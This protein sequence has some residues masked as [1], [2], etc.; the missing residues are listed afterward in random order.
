MPRNPNI[1]CVCV[2]CGASF[3]VYSSDQK[4]G[5]DRF[6]SRGCY[7][8]FRTQPLAD[9]FW[10]MVDTSGDCWEWTGTTATSGYGSISI[11]RGEVGRAHRVAWELV[12]G[13]VPSGRFV[14]HRCDNRRCVNPAHLFLGSHQD[15]MADMASKGR[16]FSRTRPERVARGE[17]N[18]THTHPERI[19]RGDR[20]AMRLHPESVSRGEQNGN[21]VL[22]WADVRDMRARSAA[23]AGT[24]E[25]GH[26]FGVSTTTVRSILAHKTW[27]DTAAT[28]A[29]TEA[30]Q[31]QGEEGDT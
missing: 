17:R 16:H 18:G 28:E 15:N 11:R 31:S 27:K 25:L 20:S 26:M 24:T 10:S 12:N 2:Q 19:A 21:H 8:T 1:P 29:A 6:C 14:C 13:A 7:N 30:I 23:G 3:L 9:R 5:R 22:T 4:R